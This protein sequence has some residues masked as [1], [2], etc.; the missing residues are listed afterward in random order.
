M[1]IDQHNRVVDYLRL[2]VTD[3]CNL[4]CNYCMPA[5]G[6]DFAQR[7]DLLSIAEMIR[8][9]ELMVS[10]GVKKIRITGGEPFARKNLMTLLNVLAELKGIENISITTNASLIGPYINELKAL[11]IR[12]INVSIDAIDPVRFFQIT[13]RDLFETVM[14]NFHR[15]IEA[16]FAVNLN[17]VVLSKQNTADILPMLKLSEQYPISV[18]FLEEM[19]FNGGSQAFNGIEWN[20]TRILEHIKTVYPNLI[21][22]PAA[23]S[24]TSVNYTV[25]AWKGRFGII[26]SFSRTFCGTCNRLR[27]SAKG[28][29]IT[30]LYAD[31]SLNLRSLIRE[32]AS[33]AELQSAIVKAVKSK[34]KN[35]F[36][37]ERLAQGATNTSMAS[38]G[39]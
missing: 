29:L 38:I 33:D 18:R 9:S 5:E 37:S 36:E 22:L 23:K 7:E 28:D 17:C 24:S 3:R 8:L 25:E 27:V 35:G 12:N 20:H 32:G 26:P 34:A 39:G 13:R 4:R 2:A 15:L 31:P 11:G 1:I 21:Q 10:M 14:T 30:C 6:I 19:P 16:G